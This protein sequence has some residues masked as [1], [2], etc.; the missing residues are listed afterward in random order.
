LGIASRLG[1]L[2]AVS[3]ARLGVASLSPCACGGGWM[4]SPN[5]W[6]LASRNTVQQGRMHEIDFDG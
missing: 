5:G 4:H 2:Q 3:M 1:A 6:R